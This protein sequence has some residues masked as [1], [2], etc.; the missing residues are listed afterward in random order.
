LLYVASSRFICV[1]ETRPLDI[2]PIKT[3]AD[4]EAALAEI[5]RLI[6]AVPGTPQGD[7]LD[8]LVTLVEACEAKNFQIEE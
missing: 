3:N 7:R 6:D 2:K 4:Y 1:I 8:I 5:E